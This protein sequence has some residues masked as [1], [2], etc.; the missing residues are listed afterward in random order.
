M[1][2]TGDSQDRDIVD[3]HCHSGNVPEQCGECGSD[4]AV[5]DWG[6]LGAVGCTN[7]SASGESEFDSE[8]VATYSVGTPESDVASVQEVASSNDEQPSEKERGGVD[9]EGNATDK[10]KMNSRKKSRKKAK[11]EHL[12][13]QQE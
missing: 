3:N 10:R 5:L 12:F 2:L 6:Q 7:D 4:I 11:K 1:D 9:A 8:S 13:S